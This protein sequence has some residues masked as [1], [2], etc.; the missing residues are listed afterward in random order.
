MALRI[1][2]GELIDRHTEK[3]AGFKEGLSF[4]SAMIQILTFYSSYL[5]VFY[6]MKVFFWED[7]C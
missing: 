5:D 1:R 6:L 4:I 3:N 7:F 2:Q